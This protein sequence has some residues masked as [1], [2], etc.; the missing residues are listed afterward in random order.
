M[1]YRRLVSKIF[2]LCCRD[3]EEPHTTD[4]STIPSQIQE[5]PSGLET[6]LLGQPNPKYD[7]RASHLPLGQPLIHPEKESSTSSSDFEDGPQRGVHKRDLDR[8]S[9]TRWPR[10]PCLTGRP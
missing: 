5:Q 10:H 4:D 3:C 1:A 7:T 2:Y 8:H 6:G 9:Q